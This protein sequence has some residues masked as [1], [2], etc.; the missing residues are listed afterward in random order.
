MSANNEV[1]VRRKQ[2]GFYEVREVTTEDGT[3]EELTNEV[4]ADDVDGLDEAVQRANNYLDEQEEAGYPV[5][6]GLR[7]I[8]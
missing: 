7:I 4:V 5:E 8:N 6:Y 2:N 1:I 3:I